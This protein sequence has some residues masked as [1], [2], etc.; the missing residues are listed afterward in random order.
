[1]KTRLHRRALTVVLL[2]LA[3]I[4]A[5][6]VIPQIRR[7]RGADLYGPADMYSAGDLYGDKK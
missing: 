5:T 7:E 3:G 4:A 2:L 6:I 1:M